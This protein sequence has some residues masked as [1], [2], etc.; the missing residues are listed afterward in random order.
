SYF[1]L[2][3]TIYIY[4]FPPYFTIFFPPFTYYSIFIIL[5]P[6]RH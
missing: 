4:I 2:S 5:P 3:Q 6:T 1:N